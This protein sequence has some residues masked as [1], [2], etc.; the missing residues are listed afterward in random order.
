MEIVYVYTKIRREFG[1]HV[2]HFEDSPAKQ[3]WEIEGSEEV[4][5][6]TADLC[7]QHVSA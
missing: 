6:F 1:K 5:T 7:S 4:R 2:G 3:E